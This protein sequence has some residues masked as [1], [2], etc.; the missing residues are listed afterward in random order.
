[1]TKYFGGR[2]I[3]PVCWSI[4]GVIEKSDQ[5][6][7]TVVDLDSDKRKFVEKQTKEP[8]KSDC[9]RLATLCGR[10]EKQAKTVL[11]FWR[12]V[13]LCETQYTWMI[14]FK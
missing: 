13:K 9:G 7:P 2:K 10:P 12:L 4:F 11:L 14:V 8:C 3:F 5:K 1:M 6:T